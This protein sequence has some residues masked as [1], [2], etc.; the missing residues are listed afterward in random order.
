LHYWCGL[1]ALLFATTPATRPAHMIVINFITLMTAKL[2]AN[3]HN[4]TGKENSVTAWTKNKVVIMCLQK[5]LV[6][7]LI[8][9]VSHSGIRSQCHVNIIW[10]PYLKIHLSWCHR[11]KLVLK[12]VFSF[13]FCGQMNVHVSGLSQAHKRRHKYWKLTLKQLTS[14]CQI[15]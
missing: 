1:Y 15:F 6:T 14:K 12:L 11:N 5:S 8:H 4:C 3:T 7:H 9:W 13:I 10:C 2:N